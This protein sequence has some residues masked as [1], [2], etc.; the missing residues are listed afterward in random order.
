MYGSYQLPYSH[1]SNGMGINLAKEIEYSPEERLMR[2]IFGERAHNLIEKRT[3]E[4]VKSLLEQK[5][6]EGVVPENFSKYKLYAEAVGLSTGTLINYAPLEFLPKCRMCGGILTRSTSFCS[7]NCR[8][9]WEYYDRKMNFVCVNCG[10]NYHPYRNWK[11]S[12]HGKTQFCS[13]RCYFDYKHRRKVERAL[14]GAKL[15]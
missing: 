2:A 4:R 11:S 15:P 3:I 14:S 9:K 6:K 5:K 8:K 13:S 10:K 7:E 1:N 12:Y